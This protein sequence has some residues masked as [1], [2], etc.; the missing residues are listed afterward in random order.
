MGSHV[1]FYR[2]WKFEEGQQV[3]YSWNILKMFI[4]FFS[5]IFF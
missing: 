1:D 4:Q 3:S 5:N 2:M